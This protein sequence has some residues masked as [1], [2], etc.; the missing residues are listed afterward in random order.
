MTGLDVL[1]SPTATGKGLAGAAIAIAI[2]EALW[3]LGWAF[4]DATG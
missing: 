2:A 4:Y 3:M 1:R